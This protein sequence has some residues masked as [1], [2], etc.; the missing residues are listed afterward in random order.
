MV[1]LLMVEKV[2]I[3]FTYSYIRTN[4]ACMHV[5][6]YEFFLKQIIITITIV[7]NIQIGTWAH[8]EQTMW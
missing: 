3:F 5:Y 6:V 4:F 1:I 8:K 7:H 2:S